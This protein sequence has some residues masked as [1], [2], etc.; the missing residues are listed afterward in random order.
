MEAMGTDV[1][2]SEYC[3]KD[4]EFV[5]EGTR[6]SMKGSRKAAAAAGIYDHVLNI[7]SVLNNFK[8]AFEDEDLLIG[9]VNIESEL[10]SLLSDF[11]LFMHDISS[12]E[13]E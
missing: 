10:S 8:D 4:G 12:S 11:H 5:E 6:E 3:K 9:L 7:D 2:A 1:Q 13:S